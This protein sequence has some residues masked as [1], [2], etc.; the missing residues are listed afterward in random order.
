MS[1]QLFMDFVSGKARSARRQ[2]FRLIAACKGRE[3]AVS[4][5][6]IAARVEIS[7]RDVQSIV[8]HLVEDKRLPI[9]S[10]VTKPFGYYWIVT[11]AERRACRNHFIRRALSNLAH[12]KAY[13][14]DAI[15]GPLVG[16][17][18]IELHKEGS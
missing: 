13:D 10:S 3:R 6:E 7:S 1:E 11:E 17:L 9:G 15:V 14:S 18:E 16:Q 12:A 2:V 8:K 5:H 4:M